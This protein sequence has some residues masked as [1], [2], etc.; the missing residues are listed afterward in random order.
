MWQADSL[1]ILRI[2]L[3]LKIILF[4]YKV[5]I[6]KVVSEVNQLDTHKEQ[7]HPKIVTSRI[8]KVQLNLKNILKLLLDHSQ[9][10]KIKSKIMN[11]I[12]IF[13]EIHNKMCF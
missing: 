8:W 1:K 3:N 13:L 4:K 6:L 2:H 9:L 12:S 7:I 10:K 5:I 11:L